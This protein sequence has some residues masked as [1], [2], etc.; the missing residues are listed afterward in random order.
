LLL[1]VLAMPAI[2]QPARR[3]KLAVA[4]MAACLWGAPALQA[5]SGGSGDGAAASNEAATTCT[6]YQGAYSGTPWTVP[7][8][9]QAENYDLCGQ[10]WAYYDTTAGNTG[11]A[12][13]SDDVDIESTTDTGGGYDVGW[14]AAGEW[15]NYSAVVTTTGTYQVQLRVAATSSGKTMHVQVDGADVGGAITVPKTGG[16]QTWAT[17]TTGTFDLTAGSHILALSFDTG[18]YNVNWFSVQLAGGSGGDGGG[19]PGSDG[20][21][22]ND[23]GTGSDAGN[24]AGGGKDAGSEGGGDGGGGSN[25][26]FAPYFPTWTWNGGKSYAYQNLVGLQ[27]ASGLNAVTIAFVLSNGGCDTTQDIEDN[28]SDVDAFIANGGHVKASFGGADGTYVEAKCKTAQTWAQAIEG[29]VDSTGITDLDFDIEQAPVMT[30]AVNQMRGQALLLAQQ[31]R[32]IKVSLT[33][34]AGDPSSGL[35]ASNL[36]VVMGCVNAGVKLSHVNL[37]TMDYG[38][39]NAPVA[40]VAISSLNAVHAQLMQNISGLSSSQAW[41][42]LGVTPMIGKNDDTEVFSLADA[43]QVT[44]FVRSNHVGLVAFWSI[45]RDQVCP[46]GADYNSC[47]TVNTSSYQFTSIFE[48][49]TK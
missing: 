12:F 40:P 9:I 37:M 35:D 39:S 46:S 7:G 31:A 18:S 19:G 8:T 24:D 4:A 13:R 22:G 43:L 1:G 15:L 17:V 6:S 34:A 21:G 41:A 23:S 3:S 36:S 47:S 29:F 5:C 49:V 10:Q 33:I 42:L 2:E 48:A 11:G 27:K 28:K 26:E 16:W 14:I 32:G 38:D 25:T 30:D 44:S 20:G 45:D